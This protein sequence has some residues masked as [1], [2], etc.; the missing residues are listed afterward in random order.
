MNWIKR[1]KENEQ[2]QAIPLFALMT[3]VLF[4]FAALSFDV[5]RMAYTKAKLQKIADASALAAAMD[6]PP[7]RSDGTYYD[8]PVGSVNLRIIATGEAYA[9]DNGM[10]S[11][12]VDA[13]ATVVTPE[14]S[15]RRVTVTVQ[16]NLDHFFA[17]LLNINSTN[18]SAT[19]VA[20]RYAVW[21]GSLLPLIN[22]NELYAASIG[23]GDE[24]PLREVFDGST[25]DRDWVYMSYYEKD[26]SYTNIEEFRLDPF[27][28]ISVATGGNEDYFTKYIDV[29]LSYGGPYY[30]LSI[31]DSVLKGL[32]G[33]EEPGL[34]H[35]DTGIAV[36][37]TS[38]NP[39]TRFL[40][41]KD[42]GKFSTFDNGDMVTPYARL[43]E[44]NIGTEAKPE[45]KWVYRPCDKDDV[46]AIEQIKV[47]EITNVGEDGN[48][49]NHVVTGEVVKEHSIDYLKTESDVEVE[50]G[51][52]KSRLIE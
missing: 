4:G 23:T 16:E 7:I 8:N 14:I 48:G 17:R 36:L 21:D 6:I 22:M 49:A 10:P 33:E 32:G 38:G 40:L 30:V 20:K 35:V 13:D 52:T 31:D 45:M 18:I 5:G 37:D 3:V 2:G 25:S 39:Q 50:V 15:Q 19:A 42:D 46:G 12:L 1:I 41:K 34:T 27:L 26:P 24:I 51:L 9:V 28:G 43:V 47:L 29:L 11:N 44:I